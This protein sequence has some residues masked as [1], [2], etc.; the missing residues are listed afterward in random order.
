MSIEMR[1]F[2]TGPLGVN[3]YIVWDKESRQ[4]MV[5][6]AGGNAP[7]LLQF[8]ASEKL[9]IHFLIN[10]HGHGDHIGAN[11]VLRDALGVPLRIHE[12]DRSMLLD[13]KKNLSA[14]MGVPVVCRAAEETLQD[15]QELCFADARFKVL[16]TPGHSPGGICL[17][18]EG[19]L[20]SGDSLFAESVGRCDFPGASESQLI[21]A[22]QM[23][24]MILPPET[25]VYPGHGPATTIGWEQLH[26]PYLRNH[27]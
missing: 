1:S 5:V 14:F 9:Q 21:K 27:R 11:D 4:G 7:E 22:L 2:E 19:L 8:I 15:G 16:Y 3:C 6:D 23:K 13:A 12:A 25:R 20:F 18:G 17:Y 10:T 26:N 24:V